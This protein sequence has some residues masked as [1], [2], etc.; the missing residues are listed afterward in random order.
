MRD[1]QSGMAALE[2]ILTAAKILK[3]ESYETS[4]LW[5]DAH[6]GIEVYRRKLCADY[7]IKKCWISNLFML[8]SDCWYLL[9]N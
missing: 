6:N 8:T 7:C 2:A 5:G 1:P 9:K 3:A 4:G